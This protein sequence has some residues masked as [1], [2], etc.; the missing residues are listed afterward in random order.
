MSHSLAEQVGSIVVKTRLSSAAYSDE[1]NK[2]VPLLVS[3]LA[4]TEVLVSEIRATC[5]KAVC[6]IATLLIKYIKDLTGE[7][8]Y[9]FEDLDLMVQETNPEKN[10]LNRLKSRGLY[11]FELVEA[12][13]KGADIEVLCFQ[14]GAEESILLTLMAAV[15]QRL[16]DGLVIKSKPKSL[17]SLLSLVGICISRMGSE[18]GELTFEYTGVSREF[19]TLKTLLRCIH[20][21]THL[22]NEFKKPLLDLVLKM[23]TALPVLHEA[24]DQVHFAGVMHSLSS[25]LSL[26]HLCVSPSC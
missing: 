9:K 3:Y 23:M 8:A 10:M 25:S 13:L 26:C 2:T 17:S 24:G 16:S 21:D 4:Q 11:V 1:Q 6:D 14:S 22:L 18:A 5:G 12:T 20:E 7:G 19:T 15:N